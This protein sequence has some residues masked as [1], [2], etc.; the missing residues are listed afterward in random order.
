MLFKMYVKKKNGFIMVWKC[1]LRLGTDRDFNNNSRINNNN[2]I[3]IN[4]Y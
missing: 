4:Q 3:N 1:V 2:F